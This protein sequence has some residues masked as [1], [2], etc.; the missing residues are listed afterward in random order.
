MKDFSIDAQWHEGASRAPLRTGQ[1]QTGDQ[2]TISKAL[3]FTFSTGWSGIDRFRHLHTTVADAA[4]GRSLTI[5]YLE[6]RTTR[7]A[8]NGIAWF[9]VHSTFP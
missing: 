6:P 4:A 7:K 2:V 5:P 3:H 1:R 9:F 8:R